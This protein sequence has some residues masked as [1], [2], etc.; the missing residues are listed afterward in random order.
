MFAYCSRP[1]LLNVRSCV[2]WAEA[3]QPAFPYSRSYSGG[4]TAGI[5]AITWRNFS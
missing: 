2:E 5:F 4:S 3:C 1:C